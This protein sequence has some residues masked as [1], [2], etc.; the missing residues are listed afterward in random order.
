MHKKHVHSL[1]SFTVANTSELATVNPALYQKSLGNL[2]SLNILVAKI[3]LAGSAGCRGKVAMVGELALEWDFNHIHSIH[4][5]K[6]II[7][8]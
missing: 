5:S 3:F 8:F 7:S 2:T 1:F 6:Y 4:L